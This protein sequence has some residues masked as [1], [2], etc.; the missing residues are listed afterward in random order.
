MNPNPVNLWCIADSEY[1]YLSELKYFIYE[2]KPET[3]VELLISSS[4]CGCFQI[5][6]YTADVFKYVHFFIKKL[7]TQHR[8][9]TR[10]TTYVHVYSIP[11]ALLHVKDI[12]GI[13]TCTYGGCDYNLVQIGTSGFQ[14]VNH[15]SKLHPNRICYRQKRKTYPSFI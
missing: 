11:Y 4:I 10:D 15:V 6:M 14:G 8:N 13:P 12:P 5:Y 1:G 7:L 3:I 9:S 2:V